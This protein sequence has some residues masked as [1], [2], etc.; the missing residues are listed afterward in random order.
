ML[1]GMNRVLLLSFFVPFSRACTE[2]K[3]PTVFPGL[4]FSFKLWQK[5]EK[6]DVFL[7]KK[8]EK[9]LFLQL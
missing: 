7:Q 8:K 2:V 6:I 9:Q 4:F 3:V 1:G 5:K